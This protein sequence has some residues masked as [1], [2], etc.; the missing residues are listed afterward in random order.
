LSAGFTVSFSAVISGVDSAGGF[1]MRAPVLVVVG[2]M[3]QLALAQVGT[4]GTG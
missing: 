3:Q 1:F 2:I 4:R